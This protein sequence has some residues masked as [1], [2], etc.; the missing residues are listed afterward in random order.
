MEGLLLQLKGIHFETERVFDCFIS[1]GKNRHSLFPIH[2]TKSHYKVYFK[3][4]FDSHEKAYSLLYL[5]VYFQGRILPQ[6]QMM[7]YVPLTVERNCHAL[8]CS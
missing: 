7:L 1:C 3:V 6:F 5:F 2:E 8:D 4:Y